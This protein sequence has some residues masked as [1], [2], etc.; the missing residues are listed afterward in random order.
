MFI[1]LIHRQTD[2]FKLDPNYVENEERYK[3]IKTEILGE[4]SDDEEESGS[5][6]SSDEEEEGLSYS[7]DPRGLD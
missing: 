7:I 1:W 4:A 2:I 6:E 5:E 3:A